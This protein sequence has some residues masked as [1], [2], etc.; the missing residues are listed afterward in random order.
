[1]PFETNFVRPASTS[2]A[3]RFSTPESFSRGGFIVFG[4][5]DAPV[6]GDDL[7]DEAGEVLVK[8]TCELARLSQLSRTMCGGVSW[9][10]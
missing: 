3:R 4:E 5:G 9:R 6:G 8:D 2:G 7:M 10:L 1:L